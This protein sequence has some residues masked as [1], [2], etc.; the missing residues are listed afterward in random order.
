VEQCFRVGIKIE[1]TALAQWR[2]GALTTGY[3]DSNRG[4]LDPPPAWPQYR[5]NP[6]VRVPTDQKV[7][8]DGIYLPDDE[9]ACAQLL[10]AGTE[11]WGALVPRGSTDP[12]VPLTV[13]HPTT[14]TLVER[15]ADSGGAVPGS[16]DPVIA[17]VRLRCEAN[18]PCPRDGFWFT[19]AKVGSR[20]WFKQGELMPSLGTDY[21]LTIWQWDEDQSA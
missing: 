16:P 12:E 18:Q 17:G 20:R 4:P 13:R 15:F 11:A 19:A 3:T 5:L 10:I 7:P 2:L 8:Q 21:G 1:F 14:W 6:N 9:R